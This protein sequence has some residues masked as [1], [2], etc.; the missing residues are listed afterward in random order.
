MNATGGKTFQRT[1]ALPRRRGSV[2]TSTAVRVPCRSPCASPPSSV[3]RT[4]TRLKTLLTMDLCPRQLPSLL[5]VMREDARLEAGGVGSLVR[6]VA[7]RAAPAQ[8]EFTVEADTPPAR[9]HM[10]K[11]FRTFA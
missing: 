5:F 11:P 8:R 3:T 7:C 10:F 9:Q 1:P 6:H 2:K 4:A